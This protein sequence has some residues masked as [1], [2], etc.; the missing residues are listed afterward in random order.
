MKGS[1]VVV[2]IDSFSYYQHA[3][4]DVRAVGAKLLALFLL[5]IV[6]HQSVQEEFDVFRNL[7]DHLYE[8][9]ER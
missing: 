5:F 3:S 2:G 8:L 4:K 6:N 1:S 9:L 7:L